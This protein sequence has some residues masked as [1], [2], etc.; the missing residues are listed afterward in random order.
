MLGHRL[1]AITFG[2]V[3]AGGNKGDSGFSSQ[4]RLRFGYFA[5]HKNIDSGRDRRFKIA[6]RAARTPADT[7]QLAPIANRR[8]HGPT[9]FLLKLRRQSH[10]TLWRTQSSGKAQILLAKVP[11]DLPAE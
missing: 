3:V 9:Q 4:M 1:H 7:L 6:L 5:G 8:Q 10:E 11:I 2:R